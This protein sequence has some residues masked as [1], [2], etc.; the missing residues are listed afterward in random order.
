MYTFSRYVFF[1]TF[2]YEQFFLSNYLF[3]ELYVCYGVGF[4]LFLLKNSVNSFYFRLCL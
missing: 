3:I 1:H 2:F 4:D